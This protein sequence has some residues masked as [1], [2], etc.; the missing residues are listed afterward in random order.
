MYFQ[1]DIDHF[2]CHEDLVGSIKPLNNSIREKAPSLQR[3]T[4]GKDIVRM[5]Q[6]FAKGMQLDVKKVKPGLGI[7]D[8]PDYGFCNTTIGRL[9]MDPEDLNENLT[10]ILQALN[11]HKP[12]RKDKTGFI[13]RVML[14]C[15]PNQLPKIDKN[16]YFSVFHP[17]IYDPKAEEQEKAVSEGR[18]AII[19]NV[20]KLKMHE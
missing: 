8:E 10:V 11:E 7:A 14:Y 4:V 13:T 3:G 12:N 5:I 9:G 15:L 16:F 17:E 20:K 18:K 2:L 6:T 1:A 19:E